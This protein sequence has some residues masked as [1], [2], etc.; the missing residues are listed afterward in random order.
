MKI[1]RIKNANGSPRYIIFILNI[2]YD[3]IESFSQHPERP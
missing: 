3:F 1:L 2:E